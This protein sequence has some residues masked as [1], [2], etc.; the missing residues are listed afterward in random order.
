MLKIETTK[1]DPKQ[2]FYMLYKEDDASMCF[3][4]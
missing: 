4:S 2:S 3:L 1:M